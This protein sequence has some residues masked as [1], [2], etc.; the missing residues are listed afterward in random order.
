MLV[1]DS[2]P[3]GGLRSQG[4]VHEAEDEEQAAA[5]QARHHTAL[6]FLRSVQVAGLHA[7]TV[8]DG[9]DASEAPS[10]RGREGMKVRPRNVV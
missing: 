4:G 3:L 2:R 6:L 5:L 9:D 7:G 10:W 1:D 8:R